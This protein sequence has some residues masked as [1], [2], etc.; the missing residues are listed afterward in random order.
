LITIEEED[1][2]ELR[3]WGMGLEKVQEQCFFCKTPTRFWHMGTNNPVCPHCAETH[4][5]SELPNHRL[6]KTQA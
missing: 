3:K 1:I 4:S 6:K 5:V 2:E